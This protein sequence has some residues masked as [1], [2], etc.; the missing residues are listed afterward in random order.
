MRLYP[1]QTPH[2]VPSY[3]LLNLINRSTACW[4][5]VVDAKEEQS[6]LEEAWN[7]LGAYLAAYPYHPSD[8]LQTQEEIV[9]EIQQE[10]LAQIVVENP[11]VQ[12]QSRPEMV[13]VLMEGPKEVVPAERLVFAVVEEDC[14]LE[15]IREVFDQEVLKVQVHS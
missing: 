12:N 14:R 1:C 9:E 15:E 3:G 10:V 2:V 5:V 11:E 6:L 7:L 8:Q 13:V 4:I